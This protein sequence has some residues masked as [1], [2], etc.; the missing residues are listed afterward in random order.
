AGDP[1]AED[2]DLL[3]HARML[4]VKIQAAPPQRVA[5]LTGPVRSQHDIGCMLGS[6]RPKL[7]NGDL[8]VRENLE[9]ESLEAVVRAVDL[10]DQQYR[11]APGARERPQQRAPQ[12][13]LPAHEAA[14]AGSW[15]VRPP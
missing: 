5:D 9:Q 15:C 6:D 3:V 2:P 4:D 11:R 8:E 10:V 12:P 7:G 13:I 14:L 1:S